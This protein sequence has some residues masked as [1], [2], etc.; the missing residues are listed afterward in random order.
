[1]NL[2]RERD[3]PPWD[4]TAWAGEVAG[5]PGLIVT[6]RNS[7]PL[8][9]VIEYARYRLAKMSETGELFHV[10]VVVARVRSECAAAVQI[11]FWG[12][13]T[14]IETADGDPDPL[15]AL[16]NAFDKLQSLLAGKTMPATGWP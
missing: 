15:L 6:F 16:R 2:L 4:A 7:G 3:C 5:R 13:R 10:R 14:A 1:M 9:D 12:P 8:E 11:R